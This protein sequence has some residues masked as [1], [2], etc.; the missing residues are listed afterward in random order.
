MK[1]GLV[2]LLILLLVA[3]LSASDQ[4][5]TADYFF[6]R[7]HISEV[8]IGD[9]LYHRIIMPNTPNGGQPGQPALP[10]RG[11][12]ILIPYGTQVESI[13][14]HSGE[15]LS[16][17]DKYFIEPVAEPMPLSIDPALMSL[18]TPDPDIYSS[19]LPFPGKT[20][21]TIGT[22]T[23]RGYRILILKLRP[24]EYIPSTG[25][26]F[27]YPNLRVVVKTTENTELES[28]YRGL[29][30]DWGAIV[31]RVDNPEAAGSY[32]AAPT[33]GGRSYDLLIITTPALADAFQT[34]KDYHDT[35]GIAT[36]I[37]TTTDIGSNAPDD[38]RAYIRDRYLNDGIQ[39]VIIGADDD[40]IPAKDLFVESSDSDD[41]Y[42]EYEMPGDIYF[43]CLD[44]T[45][46]YDG[47]SYWGEPT[48]GE[49]GGDVDLIAEVY[50]GR[51]C[52]NGIGEVNN[53]VNK[54]IQYIT[55][56][57]AYLD[58]VLLVGEHLGFSGLGEYGA[59]SLDELIDGS[60]NHGNTTIGFPS[61]IFE[62][63]K[64]YDLTWSNNDWPNTEVAARINAGRHIVDHY[65]HCWHN[66]AMKMT[67]TNLI[68]M[69][70]NFDYFFMYSQGCNAGQFD[71]VDCMAEYMTTISSF[72]AFAGILNARYGWGDYGTD[73]PSHRYNREFWDAIFNPAENKT[74]LGPANHDSKE[75]N[76]YRIDEPSMRW[77]YYE[78][79]LFGDPTVEIHTWP[80]ITFKYPNGLPEKVAPDE[81]ASFEVT[82]SGICG[83]DPVP[84]SG[85]LH[86][87][88]NGGETQSTAMTELSA[89][90]YQADL[91]AL[92]CGDVL[93]FYVSADETSKGTF[94]DPDPV[95]PH[96]VTV[97][98]DTFTIFEDDFE[99]DKGWTITGGL[100]ERG[101]PT[102]NGGSDWQYGGQDPDNGYVGP[103]VYGYNLNGDYENNIFEKNLDS[104]P[105][106]CSGMEDIHLKFWRWLGVDRPAA[107]HAYI[108]IST[109]GS[110]WTTVWNNESAIRDNAWTEIDLDIS[111]L[112]D[113]QPTVYLRWTMGPVDGQD[114]CCGWNI[115][116]VRVLSMACV[117]YICGD[118][119]GD[120]DVNVS[121]A[122]SIINYIFAGGD[123]PN[124]PE[125]GD[126]NCDQTVNVSDAVWIINYVFT[127]GNDPCDSDGDDVPD[128]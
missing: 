5:I 37:H 118:A 125:A 64:L 44:G 66:W 55:S 110:V 75:D 117:T 9:V 73:G 109:D 1:H 38:V 77:C 82:V 35:T 93:E 122:V 103:N 56:Q 119:N 33:R 102:G 107:D 120:Q 7:P 53:F 32:L 72:G 47:D 76:L 18:P 91:P 42:V 21:K 67:P 36:E 2:M 84:A 95:E 6:E 11:A 65:G 90:Q 63:D 4:Q 20:S 68:M 98:T 97:I 79:T 31:S 74:R 70:N 12:Q 57:S 28:L 23:F 105:L 49:G 80:G 25:E 96:S 54:T 83:G 34:I 124:P 16:L 3:Q 89:N 115:D 114:R 40:L 78:A 59:Y 10:A 81:T 29:D 39:Y 100:W 88:I 26:L 108:K 43:A 113:N 41:P 13:E 112:A 71:G 69:L 30:E 24:V 116:D 60:D 101:V 104:P 86:Y 22:Q 19:S 106:N 121:D 27:Y 127:G 14:I 128:C 17:G 111:A 48:D 87:S 99:T 126:C 8:T 52:A 50:V 15:R 94:F 123:P 61:T 51:V 45:Y 85:T 58:D 92:A 62:M 46:N